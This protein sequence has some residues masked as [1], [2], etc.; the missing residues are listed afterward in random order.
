MVKLHSKSAEAKNLR[1]KFLR[2]WFFPHQFVTLSWRLFIFTENFLAVSTKLQSMCQ[3]E[4]LQSIVFER[5]CI[6]FRYPGFFMKFLGQGQKIFLRVAKS[7]IDVERNKLKEKLPQ[8][9]FW[10]LSGFFFHFRRKIFF[11]KPKPAKNSGKSFFKREK[12]CN[13]N[14]FGFLSENFFFKFSEKIRQNF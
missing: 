1:E 14:F 12:F 8:K 9:L 11:K 2:Q 3:G 4:H 5:N 13:T 6:K 7:S 10:L